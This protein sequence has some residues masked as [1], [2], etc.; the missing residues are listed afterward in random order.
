[1]KVVLDAN[2]LISGTITPEGLSGR[3]LGAW[4][5]DAFDLC[6]ESR[7][8][9]EVERVTNDDDLLTLKSYGAIG[10]SSIRDFLRTLGLT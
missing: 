6:T 9:E 3:I 5:D 2:V 7:I 10:I 8:I 1:M 4:R